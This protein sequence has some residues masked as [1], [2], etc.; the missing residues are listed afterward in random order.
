MTKEDANTKRME[1]DLILF[2]EHYINIPGRSQLLQVVVE[3]ASEKS[4]R[5]AFRRGL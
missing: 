5:A 1:E 3:N 4:I 2:D